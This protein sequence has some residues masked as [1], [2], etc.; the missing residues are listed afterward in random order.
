MYVDDENTQSSHYVNC[1]YSDVVYY[2]LGWGTFLFIK[3]KKNNEAT[4]EGL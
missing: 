2:N 4:F 3:K 1:S